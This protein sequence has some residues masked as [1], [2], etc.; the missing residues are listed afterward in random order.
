MLPKI[1][2]V[3]RALNKLHT[4]TCVIQT[5][6]KGTVDEET[7][8]ITSDTVTSN[9]YPCRISF[10]S[11]IPSNNGSI[12]GQS[13]QTVTLFIDSDIDVLPNS[14]IIVK[15]N[16]RTTTYTASGVPMIFQSHQEIGLAEKVVRHGNNQ[17]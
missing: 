12:L 7:G 6:T 4:S 3:K 11:S 17:I 13:V 5:R 10:K 9:E 1:E 15:Q 2:V 16:G 14:D 8:I